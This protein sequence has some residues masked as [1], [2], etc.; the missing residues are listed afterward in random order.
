[1][2]P[3]VVVY[4]WIIDMTE[5]STHYLDTGFYGVLIGAGPL[6]DLTRILMSS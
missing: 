4:V 6:I 2:L 3:Q 1:M 5:A